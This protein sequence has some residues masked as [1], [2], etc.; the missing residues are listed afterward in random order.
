MKKKASKVMKRL[1]GFKISA[2]SELADD[3]WHLAV[4][5]NELPSVAG[6]YVI[7]GGE[8]EPCLYVGQSLNLNKRLQT[9][10]QWTRAAWGY[11]APYIAYQ[12]IQCRNAEIT[13]QEL[14]YAECLMIGLLRPHWNAITPTRISPLPKLLP[15]ELAPDKFQGLWD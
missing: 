1:T 6:V 13:E 11:E 12:V 3:G 10:T 2:F 4:S 7:F 8:N 5:A 9:H 14:L 15:D